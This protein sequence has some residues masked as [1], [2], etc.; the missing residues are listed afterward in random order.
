MKTRE[1][2]P[3]GPGPESSDKEPLK[4]RIEFVDQDKGLSDLQGC[5]G[6]VVF[7]LVA[8]VL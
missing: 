6:M 7:C 8:M 1:N 3:E 5:L 2:L 4:I